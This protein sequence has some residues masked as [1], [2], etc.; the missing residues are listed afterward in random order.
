VHVRVVDERRAGAVIRI[1]IFDV[2]TGQLVR[3][4]Q[5]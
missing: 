4:E 3:E 1:R 2:E 5:P